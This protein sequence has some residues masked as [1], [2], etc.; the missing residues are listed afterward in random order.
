MLHTL[1][2]SETARQYIHRSAAVVM[3]GVGL[4]HV[5]YLIFTP[6]GRDV[7]KNLIPKFS[8]VIEARDNILYY[9]RLKKTKPQ[10]DSYDY[11]EKAEYWALIWG[12]IIMGVTGFIL[13]FPTVVGDWAPTWLIKVSELIHFYEAV[14]ATLAILV[15]HWFFVIFHPHEYPMSLTW[16]DGKMTLHSYRHHHEKHFRRVVLEWKE[17]KAGKREIER[18][19]NSTLLFTS[20]LEKNGLNPDSIIDSELSNDPE[21]RDWLDNKLNPISEETEK[22]KNQ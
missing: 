14:L 2:L 12:T 4:Y 21:L 15:W 10:F 13:W 11:T 9:L 3:I 19:S 16:I 7:L 5:F 8:D 17:Y 22:D 18:V 20:T 1:G 6:R